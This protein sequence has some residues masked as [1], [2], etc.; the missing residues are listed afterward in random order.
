M[1]NEIDGTVVADGDLG[2]SQ[3]HDV[4]EPLVPG[5]AFLQVDPKHIRNIKVWG[6]VLG[7]KPFQAKQA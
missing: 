5:A 4:L 2:A 3:R 6:T 7:G 1:S